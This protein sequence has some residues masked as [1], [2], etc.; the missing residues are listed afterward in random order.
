MIIFFYSVKLNDRDKFP[1][2]F[3]AFINGQSLKFVVDVDKLTMKFLV[4]KV[5]GIK[6]EKLPF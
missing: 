2:N 6:Y 1:I 5:N 4:T 3:M